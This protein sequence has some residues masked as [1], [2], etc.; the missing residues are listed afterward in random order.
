MNKTLLKSL[1]K[2][3]LWGV[4]WTIILFIIANILVSLKGFLLKDVLFI[5]GIIFIMLGLFTCIGGNPM[6]LSLQSLGQ[7]N[8]QYTANANLEVSRIENANKSNF[9]DTIS[10]SINTV[11]SMFAG[12]ACIIINYII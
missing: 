11:S 9:K 4:I 10:V 1:E 8:S 2:C 3:I 7:N 5:E 6:G 12:I